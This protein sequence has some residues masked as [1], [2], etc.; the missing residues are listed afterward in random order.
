M[1]LKLLSLMVDQVGTG[2]V[3]FCNAIRRKTEHLSNARAKAEDP[4]VINKWFQLVQKTLQ[5]DGVCGLPSQIFNCDETGFV[6]DPKTQ[7]VLAEKGA[8]RVTQSN[9]G[10]GR[11]QIT[12]N[13]A[14]SA[15]GQ[16]LPPYVVYKGKKL[17]CEWVQD[18]PVGAEKQ[19]VRRAGWNH[20][21]FWIGFTKF[22]LRTQ[23]NLKATKESSYLMDMPQM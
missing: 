20:L 17:Y 19:Q 21:S 9:G 13:C 16:I 10:S 15:S 3:A 14:C 18:G 8:S 22:F 7:I 11:E 1:V 12:V 5:D 4:E 6:T 2:C 23:N